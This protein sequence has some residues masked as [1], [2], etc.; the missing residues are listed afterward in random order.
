[1]EAMWT[2]FEP[3]TVKVREWLAAGAIGEP[4]ILNADFGFRVGFNPNSRLFDVNLGAGALLDVG[5]YPV[6]YSSMVFGGPPDRVA[7]LATMHENGFDEQSAFVL[8][9]PGGELAVLYTA[10]CTTT[11]HRATIMGTEGRIEIPTFWKATEAT[12]LSG[13]ATERVER[14]FRGNGY[15]YEAMEVG[16]CLREGA[17]ESAAMPLDESLSVMKTLDWIRGQW[18]LKYP[19]E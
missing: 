6:S 11:A 10:I 9:F 4:R 18:G 19:M 7:G 12:L 1:M 2:R 16:R 5:V 3:V 13:N 17:L 14:P 15:E 8:G